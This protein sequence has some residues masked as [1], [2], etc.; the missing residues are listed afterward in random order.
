MPV[1]FCIMSPIHLSTI[2]ELIGVLETERTAFGTEYFAL[3]EKQRTSLKKFTDLVNLSANDVHNNANKKR[4]QVIMVD[5]WRHVPEVFILCALP[6]T[7]G[8][9]G[10]LKSND[11][12]R[13]IVNWWQKVDHPVGLTATLQQC[14]DILPMKSFNAGGVPPEE[15]R[16]DACEMLDKRADF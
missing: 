15:G 9:L 7:F 2:D 6:M 11:Y 16:R 1:H 10:S 4:A 3:S 5:L 8:R 12:L 14:S 13:P